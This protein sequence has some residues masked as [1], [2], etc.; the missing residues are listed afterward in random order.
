MVLVDNN[1]LSALAKVDRLQLLDA[2]FEE[3]V[4]TTSVIDELHRDAVS[5]Y[6]F[7]ERIDDAKRPNDG[8]LDVVPPTDPEIQQ[9][10]AILD[11]SLS[12]AD[13]ELIAIAAHRTE[14]LL[15]DDGHV[16][17][18]ASQRGVDT[19]DLP[20]FL[21]AACE[22]EAIETRS[23]LRELLADLRRK[24]YYE[25]SATDEDYLLDYF[26]VDNDGG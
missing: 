4:T 5:G 11:S 25:F 16:G 9:T 6:S 24:D 26:R 22:L 19:W 13:A 7:V 14:I 2:V 18:I 17:A 1:V 8:R 12:Y 10:E 23:E 21:R 3:V 15:T 20:L